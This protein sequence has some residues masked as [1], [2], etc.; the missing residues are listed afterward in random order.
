MSLLDEIRSTEVELWKPGPVEQRTIGGVPWLP[1]VPFGQ[2]GPVHPSKYHIGERH[3]LRL[4]PLYGA[5]RLIADGVASLPLKTYIYNDDGTKR[6][7]PG[8]TLFDDPSIWPNTY[9]DWCFALMQSLL[10]HGNALGFIASRDG[11]GYPLSIVWLPPE[12]C[13]IVEDYSQEVSNPT[14]AR[15]YYEGRLLDPEDLVHIRGLVL[16]GHVAALSPL[17][18]FKVLIEGGLN[19]QEYAKLWFENGGFPPGIFQNTELE[20]DRDEA[21]DVRQDLV[22]ILRRRVPLVLGRDWKYE[23]VIVKPE[24]AQFV[25]TTRLDASQIAA[26]FQVPPEMI[27]GSRGDSMTYANQ[28]Q[29]T[30]SLITWTL[31]SWVRRLEHQF[32]ALIPKSRYV[33]FDVDDLVRVDMSQRYANWKTAR[34]AGWLTADEI[35]KEEDREPLPHSVGDEALGNEVLVAMTRGGSAFPK[36]WSKILDI[37]TRDFGPGSEAGQLAS[38]P[39]SKA[40]LSEVGEPTLTAK[41][42]LSIVPPGGAPPM[43]ERPETEGTRGG[44][45]SLNDVARQAF[46]MLAGKR[47]YTD[48]VA[49]VAREAGYEFRSLHDP[50]F[51]R[52]QADWI[53]SAALRR[54]RPIERFELNG[55][56]EVRNGSPVRR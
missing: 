16:A 35:R 15:Y 38:M 9:Y 21:E 8:P 54:P 18:A 2:G 44:G 6:L 7:W 45:Y 28:E 55:H 32:N 43:N 3:A 25:E 37:N 29:N 24:E 31:R 17:Q 22:K 49:D 4:A 10:L 34:D 30:N 26:I 13:D 27:G 47:E 36:D 41:P 48:L 19:R 50:G 39:A 1:F 12:R 51:T 53:M 42:A 20:V 14:R 33:K 40:P 11:R 46:G 5:V 52:D 56:A 23:P